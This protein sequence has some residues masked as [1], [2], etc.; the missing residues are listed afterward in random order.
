[1]RAAML[2]AREE[3]GHRAM[4][5]GRHDAVRDHDARIV[6]AGDAL[7][8]GARIGIMRCNHHPV[9]PGIGQQIRAG[10]PTR[11][12]MRA[13]F[14]RDEDRGPLQRAGQ[15]RQ[16]LRFGMGAATGLG[17]AARDDVPLAGDD[18]ADMRVG[19]GAAT[20]P[21]PQKERGG[22]NVPIAMHQ[23]AVGAGSGAAGPDRA[24][25]AVSVWPPVCAVTG[26]SAAAS[27][28]ISSTSMPTA[29]PSAL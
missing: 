27:A 14:E 18:A 29:R 25:V 8:L 7:P 4:R 17:P 13:R 1:M 19:P 20:P 10:R 3:T 22:H 9:G 16:R 28:S 12:V 15:L 26:R 11:A 24:G 21:L 2:L 6:Q 5:L 23:R